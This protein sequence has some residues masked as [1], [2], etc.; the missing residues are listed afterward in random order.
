MQLVTNNLGEQEKTDTLLNQ[1]QGYRTTTQEY[2][3]VQTQSVLKVFLDKGFTVDAIDKA[4]VV[5]KDKD[6]FQR[7]LIRLSHPEFKLKNVGDIKPQ[8]LLLNSFDGSQSLRL[9]LGVYRLVCSNGMICGSSFDEYR[10]VHRGNNVFEKLNQGIEAITGQTEKLQKKLEF[11]TDTKLSEH[12]V[13][14]VSQLVAAK[15][16]E[17]LKNVH[18]VVADNLKYVRRDADNYV[19][20]WTIL[21]RLQENALRG[22]LNYVMFDTKTHELKTKR[23]RAIKSI[24]KRIDINKFIWN[25]IE[26]VAA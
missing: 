15:L 4:R 21:N 26:Q 7:H 8:I 12:Q 22:G 18:S 11:L 3:P 10:V 9:M 5:N 20:A 14:S 13:D 17:H 6:G 1:T 19:D 23:L 2:V 24:Q 25:T 16:T